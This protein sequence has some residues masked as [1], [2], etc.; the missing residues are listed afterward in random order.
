M[1]IL[2][3]GASGNIGLNLTS[4][5]ARQHEVV[6][7][8]INLEPLT[9]KFP[10]NENI[11]IKALDITNQ[12]SC[13]SLIDDTVDWVIH[14]GG[15]PH[16]DSSFEDL[17]E[18]NIKGSY[19]VLE[20]LVGNK[21]TKVIVASSA[22]VN[23]AHPVDVQTNE[24]MLTAPKNLY[25]VSKTYLEQLSHY[26]VYQKGLTIFALRIGA[27]DEIKRTNQNLNRR[28]LS[29]YLDPSDF[30]H[31]IDCLLNNTG[32]KKYGVYNC[33]SDNTY[34]RLD[35]TKAREELNYSPK[36]DAFK[37]ANYQFRN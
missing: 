9:E 23:E 30:N 19:N 20:S 24:N 3:T 26:Y 21:K 27:Y 29:A 37:L 11:N 6:A 31:M 13:M 5:L 15:I 1:K 18:L 17:L 14:L 33:I 25:G 4:Y 34:K 16:P 28:D 36:F 10:Q 32:E 35:I 8:D 22:Q 7:T 2:I 12:E